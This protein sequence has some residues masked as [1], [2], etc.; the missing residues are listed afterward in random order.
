MLR[1]DLDGALASCGEALA[2]RRA[3]AARDPDKVQRRLDLSWSLMAVGDAF[4]EKGDHAEALAALHEA[5]ALRRALSEADSGNDGL[6]CDAALT[7]TRIADV[8]V[9]SGDRAGGLAAYR[10]ARASVQELVTR[11]PGRAEWREDLSAI[12]AWIAELTQAA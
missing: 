7:L 3:L 9:A 11:V 12:D 5:L 10:E 4:A 2:I 8:L 6:R 1:G